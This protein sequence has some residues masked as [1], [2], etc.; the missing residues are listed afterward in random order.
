MWFYSVQKKLLLK[1]FHLYRGLF[2]FDDDKKFLRIDM[3]GFFIPKSHWEEQEAEELR[4]K[5]WFK[6]EY[7]DGSDN[8]E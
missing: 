1:K 4:D 5:E 8:S 7:L 6:N 2:K 3:G